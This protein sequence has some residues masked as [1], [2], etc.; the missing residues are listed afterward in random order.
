MNQYA[1]ESIYS[2]LHMPLSS[3]TRAQ[4][5]TSI[6]RNL[7]I[8]IFYLSGLHLPVKRGLSTLILFEPTPILV[9]D[10]DDRQWLDNSQEPQS[11]RD[12]PAPQPL[13]PCHSVVYSLPYI[14]HKGQS[15]AAKHRR[16]GWMGRSNLRVHSDEILVLLLG[17]F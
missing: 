16:C 3:D 13:V 4:K 17:L 9:I 2:P 5:D 1:H 12:S 10:P 11:R 8:Q 7:V 6:Q 15:N 14:E